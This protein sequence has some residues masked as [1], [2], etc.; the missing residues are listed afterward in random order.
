MGVGSQEMGLVL[1]R[2]D[3]GEIGDGDSVPDGGKSLLERIECGL[4]A[5]CVSVR[6][7]ARGWAVAGPGEGR[8]WVEL[9]R[10][11]SRC[12]GS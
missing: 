6:A 2:S 10:E 12:G 5:K 1:N 9:M 3:Y 7:G 11:M 4:A 8:S